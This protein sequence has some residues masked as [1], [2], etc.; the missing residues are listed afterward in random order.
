MKGNEIM[1]GKVKDVIRIFNSLLF[2][3]LLSLSCANTA[4][5]RFLTPD[6]WDPILAGV[7]F[8][9]YAYGANDPI[10]QSDPNGHIIGKA[11]S[12]AAKALAES[13]ARKAIKDAIEKARRQAIEKAWIQERRMVMRTG[14]GTRKWTKAQKEELVKHGK[15]KGYEGDHINSVNGN[16]GLS[17]NPDNI[18]FVT[19][20]QHKKLH[21]EMGGTQVPKYGELKDRSKY[22]Y[23]G[24]DVAELKNS[25]RTMS[26]AMKASREQQATEAAA[27]MAKVLSGVAAIAEFADNFDP[28]NMLF[29][30]NGAQ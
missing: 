28:L 21:S 6:T 17:G 5:A 4:N 11:A 24:D 16:V 10:N 2:C 3:A 12:D 7:D 8:N 1:H 27:N 9:R 14:E 25:P 26:E 30:P 19:E 22:G 20:H 23:K 13:M 18:Q 15:V 29:N